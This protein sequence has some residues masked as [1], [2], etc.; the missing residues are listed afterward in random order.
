[1][2]DVKHTRVGGT[3]E[4]PVSVCT[5]QDKPANGFHSVKQELSL[6]K[7]VGCNEGPEG[8]ESFS[9]TETSASLSEDL[10]G[11]RCWIQTRPKSGSGTGREIQAD[12]V[13][14]GHDRCGEFE[15]KASARFHSFYS[16]GLTS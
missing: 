14:A 2:P 9:G 11:K 13:T 16:L 5:T 12:E 7:C 8:K 4:F 15:K 6:W 10:Q 3:G 1:M